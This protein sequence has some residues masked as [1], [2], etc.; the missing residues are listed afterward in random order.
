MPTPY[1]LRVSRDWTQG[2]LAEKAEVSTATI[3]R[4]ERGEL[5][6]KNNFLAICRALDATPEE[7]TGVNIYSA[8]QAK[9][10]RRKQRL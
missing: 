10:R 3:S 6:Y 5:I 4:M 2:Q 9:A 7:V 8:V 1:D